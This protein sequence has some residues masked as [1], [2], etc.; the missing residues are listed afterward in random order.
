MKYFFGII[1]FVR[2][3]V[4]SSKFTG[5]KGTITITKTP[6][7]TLLYQSNLWVGCKI[8]GFLI[9]PNSFVA[10][11]NNECFLALELENKMNKGLKSYIIFLKH[12]IKKDGS[13]TFLFKSCFNFQKTSFRVDR[14]F[15]SVLSGKVF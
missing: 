6:T 7:T 13:D 11:S 2:S 9:S 10:L 8:R 1:A 4:K 3:F 15:G 5:I 12:N 14:A